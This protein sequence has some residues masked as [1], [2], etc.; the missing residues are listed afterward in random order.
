MIDWRDD[1]GWRHGARGE[2]EGT[3]PGSCKLNGRRGAKVDDGRVESNLAIV[4]VQ[5]ASSNGFDASKS[6]LS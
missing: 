6:G 4:V 3:L 5:P 1:W 2:V